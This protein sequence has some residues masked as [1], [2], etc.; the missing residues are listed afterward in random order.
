M[1][2]AWIVGALA[3]VAVIP[4][5]ADGVRICGELT[6]A[7]GSGS[8]LFQEEEFGGELR[9][10]IRVEGLNPDFVYPVLYNGTQIAELTTNEDGAG[11]VMF[12]SEELGLDRALPVPP[13]VAALITGDTVAVGPLAGQ[14]GMRGD[15]DPNCRV[16]FSDINPFVLAL[17]DPAAFRVQFPRVNPDYSA[18]LN[19]DGR[20]DF[21]DINPF[22]ALLMRH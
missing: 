16:N 7:M 6:G 17:S 21:G 8:T 22:V 10:L 14:V 11:Q 18:D 15:V 13:E 20:A 1:K 4:A 3:I 2:R 19:G 5:T 12:A 9:F